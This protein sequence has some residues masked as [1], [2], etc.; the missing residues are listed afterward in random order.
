MKRIVY[1]LLAV[2]VI[3]LISGGVW[4][5]SLYNEQQQFAYDPQ[6]AEYVGRQSCIDCHQTEH[7]QWEGSYHDLAMDPANDKTVLADFNNSSFTQFDVET[8]F[9]KRDGKYYIHTEGPTGK[10]EDFEVAY[11]FGVDPIQQYLVK[12][13]DGRVQCLTIAWDTNKKRW[14]SLYPDEKITHDDP[15][16]WTKYLQ[17]WNYMCAECHSTNLQKNYDV[18]TDTYNTTWSEIDV[19]CEACHGP[20]S[21]H[22]E[23]ANKDYRLLLTEDIGLAKLK[24][25]K[26]LAQVETC[27]K[28]HSHRQVVYP[29]HHAGAKF[30][31]HYLPGHI[32]SRNLYHHDGQIKEEVYVYGSFLQSRMY[33]ENVRCTDCHDP[34]STKL[35]VQ[36]NAL[37]IRCHQPDKYNTPSH[38]KHKVD[39]TGS[40]CV[41]CHMPET[42][43][44][45]IDPRRDHSIR[46]P[47]PEFSQSMGAPNA[48]NKCHTDKDVQWAIDWTKKYWPNQPAD[49]PHYA[50]ALHAA[51]QGRPEAK[52]LLFDIIRNPK[53]PALIRASSLNYLLQYTHTLDLTDPTWVEATRQLKSTEP[54][55]RR[56]AVSMFES[57]PAPVLHNHI[58]PMLNDPIRAV[59]VE[60]AR[61]LAQLPNPAPAPLKPAYDNAIEEYLTGLNAIAD[62]PGSYLG[63]GVYHQQRGNTT[64]ALEEY[65]IAIK[66]DPT[67]VPA[68]VNLAYLYNQLG[69]KNDAEKEFL[70]VIELS[71]QNGEIYYNLSLLIAEDPSRLPEVIAYLNRATQL[72]PQHARAH[73]NL[74][75]ALMQKEDFTN[76]E[77]YLLRAQQLARQDIDIVRALISLYS[78]TNAPDKAQQ[79]MRY[80]QQIAPGQPRR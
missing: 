6:T 40:S 2:V 17:N 9:F 61:I 49:Y 51:A 32:D 70:R 71:P 50:P 4:Y 80:A 29:N 59:R 75:V 57:H 7:K 63:L 54:L 3:S 66:L 38:H 10:M 16:H 79:W 72:M 69:R 27:A 19:S 13:P 36:G 14:Y 55:V 68:R 11:V 74:G 23:W 60:A 46:I 37:C 28:C 5:A 35:H 26:N 42:T 45:Q 77:P 1:I 43:Y 21:K 25:E 34:H 78:Q 31:D 24:G 22:V 67:F 58:A 8:R 73:Y 33:H 12:F 15:L 20:G 76:A 52:Q 41:E 18:S 65:Q 39:S 48:C 62:V 64:K 44:M 47:H 53:R 56:A 30:L